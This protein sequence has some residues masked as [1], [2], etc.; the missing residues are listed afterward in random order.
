MMQPM[1]VTPS[2]EYLMSYLEA[3]KEFARRG[4]E[5]Y[6]LHDPDLF[7][8]WK[9]TIFE[10]YAQ[11]KRGYLLRPGWV[12]STTYWLVAD[13]EFIGIGNI[14]HKLNASL[15]RFGGH[16]GY[17]IRATRWGGGFGTLNL[18]LLLEK[19]NGIGIDPALIT[20]NREN[21]ASARVIEKNGGIYVDT[22]PN[23]I[24]GRDILTCR[25]WVGTGGKAGNM[26]QII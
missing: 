23:T 16:I 22:I 11:Q 8:M 6:S 26:P 24:D 4:V 13:G 20:C 9:K 1:L 17:A 21:R 18:K 5:W 10:E 12:P 19:A 3:C 7:D 14:R 25:Y 15:R 2:H